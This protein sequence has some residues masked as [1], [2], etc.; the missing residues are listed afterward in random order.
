MWWV[1]AVLDSTDAERFHYCRK[2]YWT[3]VPQSQIILIKMYLSVGGRTGF[4]VSQV[5]CAASGLLKEEEQQFCLWLWY[6]GSFSKSLGMTVKDTGS[7]A[8]VSM[9]TFGRCCPFV[10]RLRN[11]VDRLFWTGI[12]KEFRETPSTPIPPKIYGCNVSPKLFLAYLRL[13]KCHNIF[14]IKLTYE[15]NIIWSFREEIS[16][17]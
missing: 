13:R 14:D 2:L 1:G 15:T 10:P 6:S 4:S 16:K 3:A 9:K 5:R 7:R 17:N 8:T 11:S 12:Q